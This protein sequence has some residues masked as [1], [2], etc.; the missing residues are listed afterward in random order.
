MI[1]NAFSGFQKVHLPATT[2]FPISWVTAYAFSAE[3]VKFLGKWEDPNWFISADMLMFSMASWLYAPCKYIHEVMSK[4]WG[5]SVWFLS[6][7]NRVWDM[8]SVRGLEIVWR[9]V[10]SADWMEQNTAL[11]CQGWQ[12]ICL[13]ALE[14]T[15]R[16]VWKSYTLFLEAITSPGW[17]GS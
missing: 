2:P 14:C 12:H 6:A 15:Q 3:F 11:K 10:T 4:L 17:T 16:Q 5:V 13:Q 8:G 7:V 9:H 1:I